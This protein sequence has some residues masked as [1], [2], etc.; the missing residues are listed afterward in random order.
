MPHAKVEFLYLKL[1]PPVLCLALL[2]GVVGYGAV[3]SVAFGDDVGSRAA[4]GDEVVFYGI[5]A[6]LRE[7]S[8]GVGG[9]RIV[10]IV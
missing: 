4:E 2:G 3:G 8:V 10:R 1:Y 6:A 9:T 7:G 5:G